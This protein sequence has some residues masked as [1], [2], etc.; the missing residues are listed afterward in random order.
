M[1]PV[2]LNPIAAELFCHAANV[3]VTR[4][5][6]SRISQ[7]NSYYTLL[8]LR[9]PCIRLGKDHEIRF[10][11]GKENNAF[12]EN[13]NSI[14]MIRT[15]KRSSRHLPLWLN[16]KGIGW[17][18]GVKFDKSECQEFF[19]EYSKQKFS[20]GNL[21]TFVSTSFFE[22]L[23]LEKKTIISQRSGSGISGEE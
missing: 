20:E 17:L 6:Y 5:D 10:L 12:S 4:N 21:A 23:I 8:A 2:S 13:A 9:F 19:Q 16:T 15:L 14:T 22:A 1:S 7:K 11:P 18:S 3:N